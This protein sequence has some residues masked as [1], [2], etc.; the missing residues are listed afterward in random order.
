M[1]VE[2]LVVRRSELMISGFRK[3][4]DTERV[5]ILLE[6]T[7]TFKVSLGDSIRDNHSPFVRDNKRL[8][9]VSGR[10]GN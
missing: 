3:H 1:S 6:R 9:I 2:V 5:I 10:N 8:G 4:D 7:K